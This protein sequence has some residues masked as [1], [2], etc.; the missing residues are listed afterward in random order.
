VYRNFPDRLLVDVQAFVFRCGDPL[1]IPMPLNI[2]EGLMSGA[3]FDVSWKDG[4][5]MRPV[6]LIFTQ[7]RHKSPGLFWDYFLE[8]P[9]KDIPL[10][11]GMVIDMAMHYGVV[12]A[13]LSAGFQ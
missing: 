12:R 6:A 7:E 11:E 8:L 5:E 9:A 3:S 10:S 4:D 2:G 13:H 1:H